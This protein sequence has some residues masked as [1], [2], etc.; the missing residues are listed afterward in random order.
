[1]LISSLVGMDM[2]ATMDMDATIKGFSLK[3]EV[4][5]EILNEIISIDIDDN[6]KFKI[7]SIKDIR[8]Q[9]EYNGYKV[10]LESDFDG[11]IVPIKID[12]TTGDVILQKR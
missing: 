1:M 5:V 10:S 4:L 2:R 7:I 9:D 11:I 6:T 12:I 8:E 3:Q